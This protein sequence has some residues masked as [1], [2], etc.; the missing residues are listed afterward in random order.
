[1]HKAACNT[2]GQHISK[3]R[4]CPLEEK[5]TK[6]KKERKKR[7]KG[8]TLYNRGRPTSLILLLRVE[9]AELSF[10][11]SRHPPLSLHDLFCVVGTSRRLVS[12]GSIKV[13]EVSSRRARRA[14][15]IVEAVNGPGPRTG[16]V[17]GS[18]CWRKSMR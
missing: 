5:Q 18:A 17:G 6:E 10:P 16:I 4:H 9:V 7:Q 3:F 12:L 11:L 2:R 8:K 14:T 15:S 13:L 1:M